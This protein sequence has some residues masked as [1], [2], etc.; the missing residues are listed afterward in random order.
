[1]CNWR[2]DVPICI[3]TEYLLCY[4]SI[5]LTI[6]VFSA[7]ILSSL[8]VL[9]KETKTEN[10]HCIKFQLRFLLEL[11][12]SLEILVGS[13]GGKHMMEILAIEELEMFALCFG[14][15]FFGGGF[16]VWNVHFV[17]CYIFLFSN[18]LCLCKISILN[19]WDNCHP[20]SRNSSRIL[21]SFLYEYRIFACFAEA[22]FVK[23]NFCR[24]TLQ[25]MSVTIC[26]PQFSMNLQWYLRTCSLKVVNEKARF[27]K[28]KK[29]KS[30]LFSCIWKK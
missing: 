18:I 29:S 21:R 4:C 1:M 19:V 27:A 23:F 14:W 30:V 6:F 20:I 9:G 16:E 24:S 2:A 22:M 17:P 13:C 5:F 28:T 12:F 10:L 25:L 26:F 7:S 8:F 3:R 15:R 11:F